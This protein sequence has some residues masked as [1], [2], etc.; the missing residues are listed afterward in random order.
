MVKIIALAAL[1]ALVLSAGAASA[2]SVPYIRTLNNQTVD[3]RMTVRSGKT[4]SIV[5]RRSSGPTYTTRVVQRATN[6][7]VHI[8]GSNRIVYKSRLGYVG[9]DAFV[10]AR[11]GLDTRNNRVTRTVRIAVRVRP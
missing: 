1:A 10:Y 5:L 8:D 4:C 11:D 9:G 7:S 6:G 3:G 2:C